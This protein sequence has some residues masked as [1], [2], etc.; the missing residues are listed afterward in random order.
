MDL[1]QMTIREA[2]TML[3]TRKVTALQLAE[4]SL[5]MIEEKDPALHAFLEVFD[6]VR[7]RARAADARLANGESAPLLGI[8][9]AVK[10]NIVIEGKRATSA[11]KILEGYIAP[12][13]AHVIE[14][15][16]EA[17]AIIVGRT[18]MDEFALGSST[19][20]SAFGPTKNPH[21]PARVPGG[22]SGGSAAAVASGMVFAALGSDTGGSVRQ[23]ASFCG[24]VGLK[25]T[26]GRVSR[27]GL[28]AAASSLDQI[29][30]IARSIDDAALVLKSIEG[31]DERDG[32][33]LPDGF[34]EKRSLKKKIGVPRAFVAKGVDPDVRENF[35]KTLA[36]LSVQGY[37]I[38]DVLLPNLDSALAVYYI[39]NPAEVSTNLARYDGLRYGFSSPGETLLD[40]YKKTRGEGFGKE[41]RRRI[42]VGTFVLSAGYVDAFYRKAEA[43]C[44]II[45]DDFISVFAGVDAIVTP[46]TPTPAF[47]LGEKEDPLAMYAADIFTVPVNLAGLPALSAPNGSVTREGAALPTGFQLIGAQGSESMLCD[48]A[49]TLEP[50]SK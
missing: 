38:V 16:Q 24:V 28:M 29:G 4:M 14:K 33:S 35:E 21:D 5:K 41:V 48:I 37:E 8:P 26:Y 27:Y 19:E 10:D 32:T 12:Y 34:F 31:K 7:E 30:V 47:R 25:P 20:N 42:L 50:I 15:L 46:T 40:T 18:N 39:I 1:A 49:R 3:D 45:R 43:A 17:G 6:D 11:S 22:S 23:P 36:T 13:S 2:R 44:E 9:I